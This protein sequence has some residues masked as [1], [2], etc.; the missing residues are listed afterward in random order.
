MRCRT[1]SSRWPMASSARGCF[2]VVADWRGA[3]PASL[4]RDGG[5]IVL[6]GGSSGENTAEGFPRHDVRRSRS[7]RRSVFHRAAPAADPSTIER[8][9]E[10]SRSSLAQRRL[11]AGR[12]SKYDGKWEFRIDVGRYI[13]ATEMYHRGA[14]AS[15]DRRHHF[16]PTLTTSGLAPRIMQVGCPG[17]SPCR[18]R[19]CPGGS[20]CLFI[21]SVAIARRRR[22]PA[23]RHG[24]PL[25]ETIENDAG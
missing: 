2:G 5:L 8:R 17:H 19:G 20:R 22:T 13:S 18:C 3:A 7:A 23:L 21:A 4:A 12:P 10:R 9:S 14:G 25:L 1:T 24:R 15:S 11:T 6:R 16:N